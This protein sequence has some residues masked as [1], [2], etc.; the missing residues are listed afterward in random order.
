MKMIKGKPLHLQRLFFY[1]SNS[2]AQI[3]QHQIVLRVSCCVILL[4]HLR[5][6]ASH[7]GGR[8]GVDGV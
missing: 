7:L 5:N 1:L 8:F 6:S 3:P 4:N 2:M